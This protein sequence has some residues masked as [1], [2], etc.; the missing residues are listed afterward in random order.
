MINFEHK[1]LREE[2]YDEIRSMILSQEFPPGVEIS[3]EELTEKLGVSHTPIREALNELNNEGL[4]E[5]NRRR[6]ISIPAVNR[7][8]I[9]DLFSI[10][11]IFEPSLAADIAAN[12]PLR[13]LKKLK[14]E[15]E[16]AFDSDY[17]EKYAKYF[18]TDRV[19]NSILIEEINNEIAKKILKFLEN[20]RLRIKLFLENSFRFSEKN[21]DTGNREHL[22]IIDCLIDKS[23]QRVEY[24]LLDHLIASEGRIMEL[25]G[26]SKD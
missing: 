17:E 13:Q 25:L 11:K 1:T 15:I 12:P 16:L 8:I 23:P 4:I 5:Y 18:H 21:I 22:K 19:M 7:K 10:R 26:V 14:I 20:Y 24:A 9:D 3:I 2:A 6:K